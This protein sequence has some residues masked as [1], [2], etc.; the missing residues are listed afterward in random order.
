MF[1]ENLSANTFQILFISQKSLRLVQKSA[2]N[3]QL[4]NQ[5]IVISL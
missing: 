2:K 1:H 3:R 5:A 4:K